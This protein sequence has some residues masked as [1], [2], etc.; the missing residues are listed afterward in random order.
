VG[1]LGSIART[2]FGM[3]HR[4]IPSLLCGIE[5]LPI[6]GKVGLGRWAWGLEGGLVWWVDQSALGILFGT[7]HRVLPIPLRGTE[8]YLFWKRYAVLHSHTANG[9]FGLLH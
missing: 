9:R 8:A 4:V 6:P 1:E 7:N 3:A 2:L 5:S